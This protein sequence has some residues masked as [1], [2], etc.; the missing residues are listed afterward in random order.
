MLKN[1]EC[2]EKVFEF[3]KEHKMF[4]KELGVKEQEEL[5][6][7]IR[8]TYKRNKISDRH[9]NDS[10]LFR[11]L[12]FIGIIHF[13][14]ASLGRYYIEIPQNCNFED[15]CKKCYKGKCPHGYIA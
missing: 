12:R 14:K 3:I 13:E 6:K 11:W 10:H 2:K 4:D 15:L 8:L 5:L 7:F 9:K 1:I